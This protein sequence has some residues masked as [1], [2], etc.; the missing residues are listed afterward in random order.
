MPSSEYGVRDRERGDAFPRL[1][2]DLGEI[3]AEDQP[4]FGRG[5][6]CADT[7]VESVLVL[8]PESPG[9]EIAVA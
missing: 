5:G 9:Q 4:V 8:K 6:C 7:E 1:A 3:A 2:V